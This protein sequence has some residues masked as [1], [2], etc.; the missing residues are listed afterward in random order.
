MRINPTSQ[1]DLLLIISNFD[2]KKRILKLD[3]LVLNKYALIYLFLYLN[4][5][6]KV[7]CIWDSMVSMQ[8]FLKYEIKI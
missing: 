1:T 3:L 6:L 7:K 4:F 8:F 5:I 2:F